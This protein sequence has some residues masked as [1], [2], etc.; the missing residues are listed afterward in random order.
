MPV[1]GISFVL[2]ESLTERNLAISHSYLQVLQIENKVGHWLSHQHDV[3]SGDDVQPWK[4][5]ATWNVDHVQLGS[6]F[7]ATNKFS[8]SESGGIAISCNE[9]PSLS[10]MYPDT[11]KEPIILSNDTIYRSATFVNISGKEYLATACNEDGCLYLWDTESNTPKNVFDPMLPEDQQYKNMNTCK[12][13]DNIVGYGEAN[14]SPDGSRRVFILKTDTEKITLSSTLRLFTPD[15]ILDMC[16]T[17]VDG[18]TPCVPLCAPLTQKIIAVEMVGGKTRWEV[19]KEEMGE[20][21]LPCSICTDDDNKVYVA[22]CNQDMIHLLSAE[23]GSV[24]TSINLLHYR[25]VSPFAVRFQDQCIYVE[26]LYMPGKKYA[27]SKF[28]REP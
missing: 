18:G 23:E 13:R 7:Y 27:I 12:L 10:V 17:E 22:D 8:V 14:V 6:N 19:G 5:V 21:F 1:K 24:V 20:K 3:R 26:H 4:L 9:K 15:I 16:Y 25:I 11:D 28:K 2:V